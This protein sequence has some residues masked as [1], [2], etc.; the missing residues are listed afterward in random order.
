MPAPKSL[1]INSPYERPGKHWRQ[2]RDGGLS[3]VSERR[4]AGYEI[5][6]VRNNTRRTESLD[7]VNEIRT[8][9]D[10]W[11]GRFTWVRRR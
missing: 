4:S 8:R 7:R 2:A 5:F 3:E 11:R 9:V 6:D 1:I 10:A